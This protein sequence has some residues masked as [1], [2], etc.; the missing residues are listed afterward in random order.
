MDILVLCVVLLLLSMIVFL[1]FFLHQPGR[2]YPPCPDRPL[3]IFGHMFAMTSDQR[4]LFKKWREQCGDIYSLY[5]GPKVIVVLNGYELIQETLVKRGDE[6]SDRPSM[7]VDDVTGYPRRGIITSSGHM[8]REQRSVALQIL[9]KFGLG[10]N[11]LAEK[12]Q[13]EVEIYLQHLADYNGQPVDIKTITNLSIANNICSV[14]FGQ[15]FDYSDKL[16]Q[17]LMII[18]NRYVEQLNFIGLVNSLPVLRYIP[19]GVFGLRKIE[20]EMKELFAVMDSFIEKCKNG[21][22]GD[23]FIFEYSEERRKRVGSGADTTMDVVNLKRSL[24]DLFVAG[25]ETTAT[26]VHWFLLYM[27]N[28]PSVQKRLFREIVEHVG[29]ERSPNLQDRMQLNFLNATILETQ[30][31]ASVAPSAVLHTCTRDATIRGYAIQKGTYIAPNL[32]SVLHDEKIWGHDVMSFKPERFLDRDGQVKV[33]EEFIPFSIGKRACPGEGLARTELFIY[34][35]NMIQ[36][37]EFLPVDPDHPP[38]L[39][40]HYGLTV[41]PIPYQVKIVPRQG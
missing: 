40:Y 5:M 30:R 16:F 33:P 1:H 23:N 2:R 19:G 13:E 21:A 34:I 36:R 22:S 39:S 15:R 26:T 41:T 27:L 6:F 9:K 14:L 20:L 11:I 8:W 25:S 38:P 37:F 35:S 18:L 3:P 31:L 7:V 29:M 10:K 32:D 4:S 28:F 24:F 17:K 12:I